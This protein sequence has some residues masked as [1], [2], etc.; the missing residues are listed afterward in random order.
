MSEYR[1]EKL[2][3]GY[4]PDFGQHVVRDKDRNIVSHCQTSDE[5]AYKARKLN[6]LEAEKDRYRTR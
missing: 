3:Q 2:I 5:A 6:E 1:T 4:N